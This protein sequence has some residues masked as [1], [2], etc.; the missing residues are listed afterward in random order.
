MTWH[1]LLSLTP[2]LKKTRPSVRV[3][4]VACGTCSVPR[5]FFPVGGGGGEGHPEVIPEVIPETIPAEALW[6]TG[7]YTFVRRN[8][9]FSEVKNLATGLL[10]NHL[11]ERRN[12]CPL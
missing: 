6:L 10:I 7:P 3:H 1:E 5:N 8:R 2:D 4:W 11:S 12:S 9:S